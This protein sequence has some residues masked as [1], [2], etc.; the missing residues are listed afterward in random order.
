MRRRAAY[1]QRMDVW[2]AVGA[3]GDDHN[4]PGTEIVGVFSTEERAVEA[5]HF[6]FPYTG[7]AR[8]VTLDETPDWATEGS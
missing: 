3:V 8:S 6:A 4:D 5:A 7:R 2:L 1:D